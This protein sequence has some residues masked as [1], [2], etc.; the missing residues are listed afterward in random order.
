MLI[1][2]GCNSENY[3]NWSKLSQE[4]N[5]PFFGIWGILTLNINPLQIPFTR[6]VT[7]LELNTWTNEQPD[8]ILMKIL[9]YSSVAVGFG[10]NGWSNVQLK[11]V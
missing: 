8:L 5:G 4:Y 7:S 2:S 10:P 1:I 3:Y 11:I 6:L 9:R